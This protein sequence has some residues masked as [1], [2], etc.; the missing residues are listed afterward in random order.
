LGGAG[1]WRW[2]EEAAAEQLGQRGDVAA[3]LAV[4]AHAAV[5]E[6]EAGAGVPERGVEVD[7]VRFGVTLLE[8]PRSPLRG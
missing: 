1:P 3:A 6:A 7:E 4:L 8:R 5:Q 2:S